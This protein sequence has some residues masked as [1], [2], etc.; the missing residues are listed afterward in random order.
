M[1]VAQLAILNFRQE[2]A[3]EPHSLWWTISDASVRDT[4][5]Q[6]I[7]EAMV[8]MPHR[9]IAR[10]IAES[11]AE[12]AQREYQHQGWPK[13]WGW[14]MQATGSTAGGDAAS[15]AGGSGTSTLHRELAF[16]ILEKLSFQIHEHH[17][18]DFA[19]LAAHM[20]Y[21]IE[22]EF[23]T[24]V[25][26]AA[27]R[28]AGTLLVMLE[29]ST[30]EVASAV[31]QHFMGLARAYMVALNGFIAS[32]DVKG[33]R[34]TLDM[35]CDVTQAQPLW[36]ASFAMD[37]IP[38]LLRIAEQKSVTS[39]LRELAF[40]VGVCWA[41]AG[42]ALARKYGRNNRVFLQTTLPTLFQLLMEVDDEALEDWGQRQESVE[43]DPYCTAKSAGTFMERLGGALGGERTL[44]LV[45]PIAASLLSQEAWQHRHAGLMGV[46]H[47][48]EHTDLSERDMTNIAN[49]AIK[50]LDDSQPQV[51]YA[52]LSVLGHV[53]FHMQPWLQELS[54]ATVLPLLGKLLGDP[55]PRVATHAASAL[56]NFTMGCTAE[57][58]VPHLDALLTALKQ[59]LAYPGVT[60]REEGISAIACVVEVC[61]AS[62]A[63]YYPILMPDILQV[64]QTDPASL[65]N[66]GG[67][68][69]MRP[70]R[71]RA[72]E[73]LSA[74]V[75]SRPR[76][77]F[78]TVAPSVMGA[79]KQALS[80]PR[81]ADDPLENHLWTALATITRHV[82]CAVMSPYIPIFAPALE[83]ACDY[84]GAASQLTE[85]E[86]DEMR[87]SPGDAAD[88]EE[89]EW[90]VENEDGHLVRVHAT[91]L[92]VVTSAVRALRAIVKECC[93]AYRPFVPSTLS[94]TLPM[95]K[96]STHV[97]ADAK[98]YALELMPALVLAAASDGPAPATGSSPTAAVLL[99]T[100]VPQLLGALELEHDVSK[101][102]EE[103]QCL[104]ACVEA[105]CTV[106]PSL[107][108][109]VI[110]QA[111]GAG[112]PSPT[113]P[114][115]SS[116]TA[117]LNLLSPPGAGARGSVARRHA[118]PSGT[119]LDAT[120]CPGVVYGPFFQPLLSEQDCSDLISAVLSL[121]GKSV[122]RVIVA[123][124][125]QVVNEE[126]YDDDELENLAETIVNEE[127]LQ[128][129][130]LFFFGS[131]LK[132][133]GPAAESVLSSKVLPELSKLTH[134]ENTEGVQRQA[135]FLVDDMLEHHSNPNAVW[136][137]F[138][139]FL[140]RCAESAG[141]SSLRHASVYGL[142]AA[143]ANCSSL[144]EG[145]GKQLVLL[146]VRAAEAERAEGMAAPANAD[147]HG[148]GLKAAAKAGKFLGSQVT[149]N[150]ISALGK[151][152]VYTLGADDSLRAQASST[153]AQ[154]L[155]VMKF[156]EDEIAMMVHMTCDRVFAGDTAFFGGTG[157]ELLATYLN[158]CLRS[159][160]NKQM[161]NEGATRRL[162][163]TL[164]GIQARQ[165]A[166]LQAVAAALPE[167]SRAALQQLLGG[168]AGGAASP[169]A[170][171]SPMSP[172]Q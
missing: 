130:C 11:L 53:A 64:V 9:K 155:D 88:G 124:Q 144:P 86:E 148:T 14:L 51:R 17:R 68:G 150:I 5:K 108:E 104:R 22:T 149:D 4:I 154:L 172:G 122:Q 26:I 115:A 38:V 141:T 171:S 145:T 146:L 80:V 59:H 31:P 50:M 34:A 71:A 143:A 29:Q 116:A 168:G 157:M 63:P 25:R 13:L 36:F 55:V 119:V 18:G 121:H 128:T 33:V 105:A 94:A 107:A 60:A 166:Q 73:C 48:V 92:E 152:A 61:G 95:L 58:V 97:F 160:S 81:E 132:T 43:P 163:L 7:L 77:E 83:G 125:E 23:P 54:H 126:M 28:A 106:P 136:A 49:D 156:D 75:I 12:I 30:S 118:T 89:G 21:G 76:E 20:A 37:C 117:V 103:M 45:Y 91:S 139:S 109:R 142:G 114:G 113:S 170:V 79:F 102:V 159:M 162:Q 32:S 3:P 140:I 35:L 96:L 147:L 101:Q 127:L 111:G 93:S 169:G 52:A 44:K 56:M 62:A 99:G 133:H 153:V 72:F 15:G 98:T 158:F 8:C 161:A 65:K 27:M 74:L 85:A 42:P 167:S 164:Q 165:P 41:E 135:V 19:Q 10:C 47:L 84:S 129:E 82:G 39:N 90:V 100:L 131:L 70:M 46:Y 66:V 110:Q 87:Q 24:E 16:F 137:E 67:I 78:S 57:Y 138:G 120:P 151:V 2:I 40:E 112:S 6:S 1:A 123:Q 134:P 69:D